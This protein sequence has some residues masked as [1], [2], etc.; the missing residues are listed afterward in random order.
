M[1]FSS[2]AGELSASSLDRGEDRDNPPPPRHFYTARHGAACGARR[3]A[4]ASGD[5][6]LDGDAA[7]HGCALG[8]DI[9]DRRAH[10]RCLNHPLAAE[11]NAEPPSRCGR[12]TRG[13]GGG[14][15]RRPRADRVARVAVVE[16]LARVVPE[17]AAGTVVAVLGAPEP[18]TRPRRRS[19]A[20]WR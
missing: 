19:V 5:L 11:G 9:S 1:D 3:H 10:I 17:L 12:R 6:L 2:V 15:V 7:D 18:G 4:T 13:A 20:P 8:L 14:T 16:L